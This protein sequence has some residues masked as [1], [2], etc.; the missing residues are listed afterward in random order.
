VTD[1]TRP[2]YPSLKNPHPGGY[3]KGRGFLWQASWFAVQNLIFGAW[4]CPRF[5]RPRLLRLFGA[6]IGSNPFIRHRVRVLWPWKLT[7]GDN[8]VLGEDVWLLNLEPITIG[9]DV[10]LSQGAFLCSGS[11]DH[12]SPDFAYD[13]GPIVIQDGVWVA[14]QALILRGVTVGTGCVIGARAVVKHDVP[15]GDTVRVNIV[16]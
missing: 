16:Y 1:D 5:L 14:A 13:N 11:H 12:S 10:C 7:L 4:W 2:A 6:R 15:A 9:S 3:D 8:A